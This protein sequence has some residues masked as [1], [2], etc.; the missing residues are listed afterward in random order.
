M[1]QLDFDTYSPQFFWM[2]VCFSVLYL[3]ISKVF[4]HNIESSID[5]RH[6]KINRLLDDAQKLT[7]ESELIHLTYSK[8]IEKVHLDAYAMHQKAIREFEIYSQAQMEIIRENQEK[9][10][11]DLRSSLRLAEDMFDEQIN[12]QAQFLKEKILQKILVAST[13][14]KS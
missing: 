8:D 5:A 2:I 10:I 13:R 11:L 1:P 3:F 7:Q 14:G 12:N 6:R 9:K 4:V